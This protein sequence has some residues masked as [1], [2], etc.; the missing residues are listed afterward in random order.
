MLS[1]EII[2]QQTIIIFAYVAIGWY[3]TKSG[4]VGGE[5][6]QL[7]SRFV[8]GVTLPLNLLAATNVEAAPGML[9]N[10]VWMFLLVIG[11]LGLA[12][13]VG[14]WMGRRLGYSPAKR[15][16]FTGLCA[17]PNMSFM[18]IPL[19]GA[20]LGAVGVMY[21]PACS[22]AFNLLFFTVQVLLFKPDEKVSLRSFVTPL[23]GAMLTAVLMIAMGWRLPL[24]PQ[25]ICSN[26]G[27]IT[28]PMALII[29]GMMLGNS[30]VLDIFRDRMSYLVLLIRNFFWPLVMMLVLSV[31]PLD[32]T[33]ELALMVYSVTPCANLT[34]VF[35]AQSNQEPA[36]AG[37]CVLFSTLCSIVTMP[38]VLMA[39]QHIL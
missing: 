12:T 3:T 20:L 22:L 4:L 5:H 37:R 28:S 6:T 1:T 7:F 17:Y 26:V 31:L 29:V 9:L 23:N 33:M 15:A 14:L 35:A 25:T 30:S 27:A 24:I 10:M 32:H 11:M 8:T 36:L 21:N 38:L 2:I 18:G 13:V 19:C 34:A 39:A 16:V